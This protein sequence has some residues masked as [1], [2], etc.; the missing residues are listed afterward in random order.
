MQL[1][2]FTFGELLEKYAIEAPDREF[3]VY[4]D[5]NLRFTY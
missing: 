5:R 4:A 2:D 1:L 3:M